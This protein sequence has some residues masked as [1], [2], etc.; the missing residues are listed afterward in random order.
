MPCQQGKSE[1]DFEKREGGASR[2]REGEEREV[3]GAIVVCGTLYV[4]VCLLLFDS[5]RRVVIGVIVVVVVQAQV[6]AASFSYLSR[7]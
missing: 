4:C 2:S 7:C 5:L 3:V 1:D 6:R